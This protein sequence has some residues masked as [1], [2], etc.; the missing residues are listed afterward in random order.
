MIAD[1]PVSFAGTY[2]ITIDWVD[3]TSAIVPTTGSLPIQV[4]LEDDCP[5]NLISFPVAD[6]FLGNFIAGEVDLE[7][8]LNTV[9]DMTACSQT[10]ELSFLT[11]EPELTFSDNTNALK[12]FFDLVN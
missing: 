4:I 11:T 6:A 1:S 3:A 2:D 7:T 8:Y 12:R 9:L 10:Y 5:N